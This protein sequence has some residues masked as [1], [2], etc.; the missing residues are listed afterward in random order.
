MLVRYTGGSSKTAAQSNEPGEWVICPV[1]DTDVDSTGHRNFL[2]PANTA[3]NE[4][5]VR[6]EEDQ[7]VATKLAEI[8]VAGLSWGEFALQASASHSV[9][10]KLES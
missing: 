3:A 8:V 6:V 4:V 9:N 1:P 5:D 7:T 10:T 2:C